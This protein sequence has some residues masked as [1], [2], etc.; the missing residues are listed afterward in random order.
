MARITY[1]RTDSPRRIRIAAPRPQRMDAFLRSHPLLLLLLL[2]LPRFLQLGFGEMQQWDESLYALRTQVILRFG[3]LWDQSALMLSGSYYSAHPPLYVWSSLFWTLLFGEH[4]WVYRLTSALAGAALLPL[5]YRYARRVMPHGWAMLAAGFVAVQPLVALYARLGQLDLLLT[6]C[7]FAALH[8]AHHYVRL[9]ARRDFWLFALALGAALMTKMLFALVLPAA[10]FIAAFLMT[11]ESRRRALRL[12]LLG[13]ATSLPLWLP[14]LWSFVATHGGGDPLYLFGG[15]VPL[16]ATLA[17]AEGTAKDSGIFFYFNQL[18]VQLGV[19]TPFAAIGVMSALRERR[20]PA[21][22][23]AAVYV[24]LQFAALLV[25]RSSF[26]VYLIPLLPPLIILAVHGL[27]VLR[28]SST[29]PLFVLLTAVFCLLWSL[30][31]SWRMAVKSLPR[32]LVGDAP[33]GEVL[34][35]LFLLL[36]ALLLGAGLTLWCVR[37]VATRRLLGTTVGFVFLAFAFAHQVW[38]LQVVHP[39]EYV[40]G[41]ERT[42]ATIDSLK[43]RL[44]VLVG[45]GDNP[46]LSWYLKGLDIG[47]KKDGT[48]CLRMQPRV[49]GSGNIQSTLSAMRLEGHVAVVVERDE[50]AQG[51]YRSHEDVVPDG[52]R[53]VRNTRR[54]TVAWVGVPRLTSKDRAAKI[55]CGIATPSDTSDA[56]QPA[57]VRP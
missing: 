6:L 10:V 31:H 42:A 12:S 37:R 8:T 16:G 26:E 54:Y 3:A 32:M 24:A 2:Q 17:G 41:A 51:V 25:M 48:Q 19:L 35:P 22:L 23:L 43:P 46:Q 33:V 7:M 5:V 38:T 57:K 52:Y 1:I 45:N 44:L 39:R 29:Q 36:L 21:L 15:A 11:G 27:R 47:W 9:G 20:S 40:D 53:I 14:W 30:S 49:S 55:S 50:I 13:T 4:V 56:E 34:P 28:R 18:V